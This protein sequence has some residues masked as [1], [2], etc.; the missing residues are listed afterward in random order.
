MRVPVCINFVYGLIFLYHPAYAATIQ[1]PTVIQTN[2][3][4]QHEINDWNVF[5]DE[6]NG[7]HQF[8]RI[9][10]YSGHPKENA[11]LT[12]DHERSKV[13]KLTW[14]FGKQETWIA[15]DYTRTKIQLIRKLPDGTKSCTVTYNKDFSKVTAINCI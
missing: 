12:P 8:E 13:K 5:T 7:I 1:C 11:S 15:C 14:T 6:L 2:Q 4:L 3:S 9:T 10:F